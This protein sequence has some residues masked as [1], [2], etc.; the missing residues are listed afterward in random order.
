MKGCDVLLN[1]AL[2]IITMI[3]IVILIIYLISNLMTTFKEGYDPN[4][5]EINKEIA[6]NNKDDI[7]LEDITIE[8]VSIEEDPTSILSCSG[9]CNKSCNKQRDNSNETQN[10]TKKITGTNEVPKQLQ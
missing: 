7:K 2:I 3:L 4:N 5:I 6:T 9:T 1:D 8:D 10:Q